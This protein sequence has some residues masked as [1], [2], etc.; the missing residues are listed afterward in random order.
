MDHRPNHL[1][2]GRGPARGPATADHHGNAG[3]H[4]SHAQHPSPEPDLLHQP[5][6]AL[7][8]VQ[9]QHLLCLHRVHDRAGLRGF[10]VPSYDRGPEEANGIH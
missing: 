1:R 3:A 8:D 9:D 2:L 7:G 6:G 5:E 4:P 10:H